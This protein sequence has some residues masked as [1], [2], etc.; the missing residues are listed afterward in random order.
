MQGTVDEGVEP[1][2]AAFPTHAN[3]VVAPIQSVLN[4][5]LPELPGSLHDTDSLHF[6]LSSQRHITT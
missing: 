1:A 6:D 3:H 5:V 2:Y 4:H